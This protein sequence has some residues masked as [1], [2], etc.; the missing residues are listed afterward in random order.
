MFKPLS[1]ELLTEFRALIGPEYVLTT[2]EETEPWTHDYTEDLRFQPEV[3]LK[4]ANAADIS[5]ILRLCNEAGV[6]VTAAGG[7]TGLSGGMLAVHGGVILAMD[8]LNKILEIDER[9]LQA[10]V[11]PAVITQ[12]FQDAVAEKGLLY[13]VD[14][15]SRGS[16]FIGGNLAE[17]SGGMR[18]LKYGTTRD[19]VLDLEVVLPSGEIIHT[20]ARTLKNATGYDLTRLMVGSE[21]TLGIITKG[22][23]KLVPQPAFRKLM[24]APFPKGEMACEAVSAIFR[25]GVIPSALE[26]MEKDAI[27]FAQNYLKEFPFD[28]SSVE[29]HLLIEV[30]GQDEMGVMGQAEKVFAV[31]E[32]FECGEILFAD[33]PE[34]QAR[35]WRIRRTIGEATRAGNVIKEEDTCVPRAELASLWKCVKE[36]GKKYGLQAFCFGHA[37][38]GNLHVHILRPKDGGQVWEEIARK[39]VREI[40]AYTIQLGGTLS[41]EHGIG[42]V[43]KEFMD[44]PFSPIE[45]ELMK[46]IKKVFDPKGILNPGKMFPA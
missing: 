24:L 34:E 14:P 26:F 7:R 5:A 9:N 4:P 44:I 46:G 13:P 15:A 39:A 6:P 11:E 38:D 36:T 40:F 20:G 23:F 2:A 28:T 1:A 32:G 29:A 42:W 10:S 22:T 3:V 27:D 37:G 31:L 8:R 30:D 17:S 21:G 41:G 35:L 43:Q 33:S 45:L 18:A 16:C 12:V 25:A 19:Y